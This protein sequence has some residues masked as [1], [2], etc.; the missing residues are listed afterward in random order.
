MKRQPAV[1]SE[2]VRV[3]IYLFEIMIYYCDSPRHPLNKRRPL[4]S[5]AIVTSAAKHIADLSRIEG[6]RDREKWVA[7]GEGD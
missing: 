7:G 1:V 4:V 6:E 5:I 3:V 2:S